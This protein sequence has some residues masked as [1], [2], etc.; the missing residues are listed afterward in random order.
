MS[1]FLLPFQHKLVKAVETA[2]YEIDRGGNS[3][4]ILLIGPPGS[5]KTHGLD[6][7]ARGYPPSID[8]DQPKVT[9]C[10]SLIPANAGA[11]ATAGA[12]IGRL[13][14]PDAGSSITVL[15]PQLTAAMIARE[16]RILMFEEVHNALLA[17]S[18]NLRGQ[19]P[20]LLKNIWNQ[21]PPNASSSWA[22]PEPGRGDMRI[23]IVLSGTRE[24]E[25]VF[26]RDQE[27][28]SRFLCVIRAQLPAF[29]PP[30][31]FRDFRYV[32]R[33]LANRFGISELVPASDDSIAAR[34]LFGCEF[35]YRKLEYL[36]QRVAT[37]A[38]TSV[39]PVSPIEL[40][41]IA[42]E[43]VGGLKAAT[44]NPFR[45]SEDELAEHVANALP[46]QRQISPTT[47]KR[48]KAA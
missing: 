17:G 25:P 10:R 13:G 24:L 46:D 11:G 7:V 22:K 1:D 12:A 45:W 34:C 30:E 43:Q 3:Q 14:K 35:H 23:V 33:S 8:G 39:E 42:S 29:S 21:P 41:S 9:C 26:E 36:L 48:G 44:R 18:P 27:L 5:G 19:L 4:G 20:R 2:L 37:L 47:T 28:A 16:V 15:E 38:K 40:L 32:L 31:S 6:E